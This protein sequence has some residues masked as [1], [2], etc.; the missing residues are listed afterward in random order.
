MQE[1]IKQAAEVI[2]RADALFITA[3]A[4]MGV[5]SG[6]PDFRGREG[7][8]KAYPP[9]AKLGVTFTEMAN[10]KWFASHPGMAW[11]FYGHRYN[12]YRDT[13]PHE[14]YEILQ[15]IAQKMLNGS[16][17][18]T[19]NVD[20][21]FQKAGFDPDFITECHGSINHLQCTKPCHHLVYDT[22]NMTVNVDMDQFKALEP[23]PRCPRC[24]ALARPNILMFSDWEWI[25][26]RTDMQ[27]ER[28]G[29]WLQFVK[30]SRLAII[31]CGAGT[32][33]ATVRYKSEETAQYF[34]GTIIRI[35]PRDFKVPKGHISIETGALEGL[36]LIAEELGSF[37]S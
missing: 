21:H 7:F 24:D 32:S 5:D 23:L 30:G 19:S 8:W 22:D 18:F 34:N 1:K 28:M 9:I 25:S 17:V 13:S 26:S 14:G 20:G 6:L 4:G 11:A 3:G 2:S 27:E 12:L 31:E 16:F 10:P 29:D 37:L 15:R 36:K 33:V 35:N